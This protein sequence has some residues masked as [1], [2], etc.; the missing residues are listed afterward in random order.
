MRYLVKSIC[1]NAHYDLCFS[2]IKLYT[3]R[4]SLSFLCCSSDFVIL[5]KPTKITVISREFLSFKKKNLVYLY[6]L[7]CT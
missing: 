7:I 1:L 4:F 3:G 2:K 6:F 5:N